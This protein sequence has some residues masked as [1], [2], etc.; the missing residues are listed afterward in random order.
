MTFL[1]FI[2]RAEILTPIGVLI[3]Y[4]ATRIFERKKFSS[5][6][7]KLE[8]EIDSLQYGNIKKIIENHSEQLDS[9]NKQLADMRERLNTS[10]IEQRAEREDFLERE[11][12]Y[13]KKIKTSDERLMILETKVAQLHLKVCLVSECND[14][15]LPAKEDND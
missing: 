14:R 1:D 4:I 8:T 3:T 11:V 15:E 2:L 13:L 12:S 10:I 5:D 9:Y 6:I 7:K